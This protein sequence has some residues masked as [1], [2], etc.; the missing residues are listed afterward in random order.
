MH[1]QFENQRI[2]PVEPY[3]FLQFDTEFIKVEKAV[4]LCM[5]RIPQITGIT[6]FQ[7][8]IAFGHINQRKQTCR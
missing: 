1:K 2:F 5:D 7:H 4:I 8:M 3:H 6:L